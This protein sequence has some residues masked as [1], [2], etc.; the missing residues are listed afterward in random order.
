MPQTFSEGKNI[1]ILFRLTQRNYVRE[2]DR[3]GIAAHEAPILLQ[4]MDSR[5]INQRT[6]AARLNMDE[7][8]LTR[9]LNALGEKGLIK[10][11][12]DT[13]DRRS[14]LVDLTAEGRTLVPELRNVLNQ[15]WDQLFS[16]VSAE[17][18]QI[19]D[20]TLMRLVAGASKVQAAQTEGKIFE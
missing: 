18:R 20:Q 5:R 14:F 19:F 1:T 10:K 13:Q 17:D 12:R 16:T 6:L 7:G 9:T 4:L 15:W 11:T 2:F 3:F 8:F